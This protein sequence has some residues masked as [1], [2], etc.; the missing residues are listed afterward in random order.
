MELVA[1]TTAGDRDRLGPIGAIG[2]TGVFTKEIQRALLDNRVDLA[3]HSL[4]DLPTETV[5]MLTLAAVPPRESTGDALLS[6]N[7]LPFDRLPPGAKV[8]TGSLRR[9]SQLLH[10]RPDLQ[11]KDVRGNVETRVAK[12]RGGE[13]DALVLA[14]AGLKRLG[15]AAEITEILPTSIILPAVGQGALG[16]ETRADDAATISSVQAARRRKNTRRSNGRAD[17]LGHTS[18]RMPGPGRRLGANRR[19]RQFAAFGRR[20]Q[21]RWPRAPRCRSDGPTRSSRRTGR[22]V[23]D[24]L[25][26]KGAA[27]LIASSRTAMIGLCSQAATES[28]LVTH[29][30]SGNTLPNACHWSVTI[31]LQTIGVFNHLLIFARIAMIVSWNWSKNTSILISLRQRSN[32]G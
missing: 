30:H 26:S 5:E 24:E 32:G 27:A 10:V 1:I 12:L 9:Q 19:Q 7:R 23:A 11:L 21:S 18:R 15:L 31:S 14:E 6:R 17:A 29:T 13:F 20:A 22:R 28:A 25:L 4:K 2:T 16:L 3:V 8:G